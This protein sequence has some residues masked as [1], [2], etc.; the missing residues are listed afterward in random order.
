M[1]AKESGTAASAW[2]LPT[3]VTVG[4]KRYAVRTDYREIL[5]VIA[6]LEDPDEPPF[7]RWRVA[8][9]L[10]YEDW[11][12]IGEADTGEAMGRLAA[13]IACGQPDDPHKKPRKLLDW[14]QDAAIIVADV[15][16]VAGCEIRALPYLHWWSFLAWFNAIG[17]GQ[18]ATLLRVRDKVQRGQK[19]ENW[20]KDY[21]RANRARV[22]LRRPYSAEEQAER[23]R[24]NALLNGAGPRTKEVNP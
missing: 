7:V 13:F 18:L 24:L 6:A 21:Y 16:R 15:N 20:E 8:L 3:C 9:A 12:A 22:E 5:G 10:F 19:L 2:T 14:Q 11:R 17:E 1:E 23:D 4:G